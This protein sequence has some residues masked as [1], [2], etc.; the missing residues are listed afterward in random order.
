ML[1]AKNNLFPIRNSILEKVASSFIKHNFEN[2]DDIP[3]EVI[4]EGSVCYHGNI[5]KDRSIVRQICLAVMGFC[6]DEENDSGKK[7]SEY[8]QEALTRMIL[9]QSKLSVINEACMACRKER[10]IVSNL[11]R[12]CIARPCQIN[13]PKGAVSFVDGKAH[14]DQDLCIKCGRCHDV[15]PYS[16]IVKN[17]IPCEDSCPVGAISKDQI[18]KEHIDTAKCISCGKCLKSC[19][20]GAIVERS[21]LI[22]V[23][24]N[25]KD[26][27]QEV[28]AMVAPAVIGQFG[29]DAQTLTG[30]LK[31]LGFSRVV[32]VAVGADITTIKEA[33]EFTERMEEGKPFMTTSCC[34][35]YYKAVDLH[36]PEIKP[37]VS[38]TRSPMYYTAE[39][40]KQ[41]YPDSKAVF[42]GPCFAKRIEAQE[43]DPFVD[44]VLTFEELNGAFAAAGINVAAAEKQDFDDLSCAQGRGFPLTGGV[45]GAVASVIGDKVEVRAETIDGLSPENIKLLKKYALKGCPNNLLEVMCCPG[46]CIAGPGCVAMPLKATVS[47]KNYTAQGSDLN[48]KLKTAK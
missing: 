33:D 48:E 31:A 20:F 12:A 18:G 35:A 16:A 28:I 6:P 26:P 10:Y 25:L 36:V 37:F 45:A 15:C 44:F 47:V 27:A 4:P 19:P 2:I 40:V 30:A 7:L 3:A 21:Q 22:D 43:R 8:A 32:E 13:C 42:V 11:C 5:E 24:R 38:D 39:L 9:P 23:L 46:G 14:I 1:T 41:K 29:G 34:P 17:V